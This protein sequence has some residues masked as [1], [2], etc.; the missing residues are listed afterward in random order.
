MS[1]VVQRVVHKAG[2]T[3]GVDDSGAVDIQQRYQ[4]VL[5]APLAESEIITHFTGIPAIGSV[6]PSR[7][8]YYATKYDISQPTGHDKCTLDVTVHY[9]PQSWV[10]EGEGS[11]AQT[12][13]VEAWGWDDATTQREL[14]TDLAGNPVLNSAGDAFD[15]VPT[16]E[17]PSPVFTK[18]V[19]FA[20]RQAG[21]FDFNCKVNQSAVTI[22]GVSCAARTL[23]CSISETMDIANENLPYRYTIKLRWRS[24]IALIG[25]GT[26][27]QECGWDLVVCDT[28]MRSLD[29]ETGK[30]K[31]I[32][33]VSEE[34]GQ[35]AAVTSP[36]L[37][38]GN[39]QP[40][41]REPNTPVTPYNFRFRAYAETN[42]PSWFYTEPSLT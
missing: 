5:T 20:T 40:V 24:N 31:L 8:G 34:T 36:E 27:I 12:T 3:Y 14:V 25:N 33:V 21:W 26:N 30:K 2:K 16:V 6:H 32:E 13:N 17:S 42:F 41:V 35:P 1:T 23:L 18:V 22:G 19:R 15:R 4:V 29:P 37:L 7:P 28:G 10:T 11:A 39:G 38:D 9:G